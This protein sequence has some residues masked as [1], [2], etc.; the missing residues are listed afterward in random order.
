MYDINEKEIKKG[1]ILQQ[2]GFE[3]V[4]LVFGCDTLKVTAG[5]P[6]L[7]CIILFSELAK[8]N[9]II[10]NIYDNPELFPNLEEFKKEIKD[11]DV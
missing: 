6:W 10:G 1:D 11:L 9:K 4:H 2:P 3:N 7:G 5:V 8:K